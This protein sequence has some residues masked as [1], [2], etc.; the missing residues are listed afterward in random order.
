MRYHQNR[1]M[2]EK[3]ERAIGEREFPEEEGMSAFNPQCKGPEAGVCVMFSRNSKEASMTRG[4]CTGR[5]L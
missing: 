5:G 4:K 2:K 3:R 1:D